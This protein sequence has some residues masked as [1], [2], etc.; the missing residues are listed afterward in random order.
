[1]KVTDTRESIE[2]CTESGWSAYDVAVDEEINKETVER[3]GALGD[4]TYLGMLKQPFYRIEQPYYMI[5]GLEGERSLRVA[6][7]GGHEAVL[8]TVYQ[9]LER[10]NEEV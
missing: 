4:M 7:L 3:L 9:I 5:K 8:Q 1:M 10:K 2:L 6:M